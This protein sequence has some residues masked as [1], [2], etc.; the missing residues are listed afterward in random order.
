MLRCVSTVHWWVDFLISIESHRSLTN[1]NDTPYWGRQLKLQFVAVPLES[2]NPNQFD[3]L[4]T[5]DHFVL[6]KVSIKTERFMMKRLTKFQKES[7]HFW[8]RNPHDYWLLAKTY[9]RKLVK[10]KTSILSP[11]NSNGIVRKMS[12]K[13]LLALIKGVTRQ[14]LVVS[15]RERLWCREKF[16]TVPT[17]KR[18]WTEG[19]EID[20]IGE[21]ANGN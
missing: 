2:P 13:S 14:D 21:P 5:W 20:G 4:L 11:F 18:R 19:E 17:S 10:W 15:A 6:Q 16:N 9:S 8:L 3:L 12:N 7:L 1:E